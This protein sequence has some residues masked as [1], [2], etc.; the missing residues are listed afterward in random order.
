MNKYT[1]S[2]L[3]IDSKDGQIKQ[4]VGDIIEAPSFELAESYIQNNGKGYLTIMGKLI[5]SIDE[6]TGNK[7]NFEN[8]N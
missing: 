5:E 7:I 2:L 3:A 8:L 4:W 6:S 1:T